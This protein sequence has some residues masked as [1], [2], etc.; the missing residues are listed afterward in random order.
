MNR[1]KKCV[2]GMLTVAFGLA[3]QGCTKPQFQEDLSVW[4]GS[5]LLQ[6]QGEQPTTA[7][8]DWDQ[9]QGLWLMP[10]I[11]PVPLEV[12]ELRKK[13]DSVWFEVNFRSGP[14]FA[15]A[16]QA[17][18]TLEGILE[19]EGLKPAPFSL[20]QTE[21]GPLDEVIKPAAEAPYVWKAHGDLPEEH[22]VIARLQRLV[23]QYDLEPYVYT[24]TVQVHRG[25][26]PHS[27]PVLTLNTADST[28]VMLLGTFLH[29]QM[30]WYSLFLDGRLMP[31]AEI[32]AVRYP[33]VPSEFPE[34]AGSEHSTFLHLSVCFLEFK[35][36]EAVLG[37]E[38]ALAYV[39]AMSKRYYR[40]VYRTILEDMD[41]F[42]ELY[43]TH[44]LLDW[45][46]MAK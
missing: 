14:A 1:M 25:A 44:Q 12:K 29:E 39:Q 20:H 37:R 45:E 43:A 27:H 7:Q 33:K 10:D 13:G 35:A 24:K 31:V 21:F 16:I 32:M 5:T 18:G 30:H 46:T 4:E 9:N 28:D 26:I 42:E 15:R 3:L 23:E 17:D 11:I 34:G 8:F 36:V 41:L 6:S 22:A 38:Q 2:T 19:K 40:W